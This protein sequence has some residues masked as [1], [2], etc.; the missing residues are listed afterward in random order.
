MTAMAA[1]LALRAQDAPKL[2]VPGAVPGTA[3]TGTNGTTFSA[4]VK[5][6]RVLA[7][8]RDK[9]GHVVSSVG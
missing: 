7:S 1:G 6:V 4:D 5:V 9:Q 8:V 2:A 3:A